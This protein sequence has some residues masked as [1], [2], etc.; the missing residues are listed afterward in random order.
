MHNDDAT[1]SAHSV[2]GAVT[3]DGRAGDVNVSDIHGDVLLGS[4][5]SGSTHVEHVDGSVRFH[6][7]RTDFQMARLDG[8]MDL[9]TGSDLSA[10]QILGPVILK[11]NDR[12]ITLDRIQG[13]AQI[14]NSNGS[15]T[16]TS[17]DPLGSIDVTN[18]RGSVEVGVPAS[19]GFT[20]QASTQHG[21]ISDDFSLPKHGGEDS[22]DLNGTVGRGGP[23]VRIATTDGDV[24]VRKSVVAPLP[25]VAPAPPKITVVPPAPPKAPKAPVPPR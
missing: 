4:S 22:S 1:F 3:L 13:S 2:T 25:P 15:V 8:K 16:L 18:K 9:D 19:A 21:D 23:M 6:T 20:V 17:A 24:R 5:L 12:N 11:T 7:H 10:D 14:V